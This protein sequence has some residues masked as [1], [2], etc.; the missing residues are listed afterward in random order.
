MC[1]SKTA[2]LTEVKAPVLR[3][4]ATLVNNFTQFWWLNS[5]CDIA[6]AMAN[7]AARHPRFIR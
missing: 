5:N 2:R 3:K 4:M 7:E 1:H 6:P